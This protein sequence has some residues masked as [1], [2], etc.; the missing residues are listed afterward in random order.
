MAVDGRG[1]GFEARRP[2][3]TCWAMRAAST[4]ASRRDVPP[5]VTDADHSNGPIAA[6][7]AVA[8][9]GTS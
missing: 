3:S 9:G 4:S 2:Q 8:M 1:L 6:R 7:S 5:D